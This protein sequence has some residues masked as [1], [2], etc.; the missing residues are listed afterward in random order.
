MFR[1]GE[2]VQVHQD[3]IPKSDYQKQLESGDSLEQPENASSNN[4]VRYWSDYNRVYLAPRSIQSLP[5]PADWEGVDGDWSAGK[6]LFERYNAVSCVSCSDRHRM[7]ELT[8]G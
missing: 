5:D 8:A 4:T 7:T 2:V 3:P 1:S 6:D